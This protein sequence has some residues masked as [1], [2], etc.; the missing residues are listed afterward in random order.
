MNFEYFLFLV[1]TCAGI[2]SFGI[3][4]AFNYLAKRS[5]SVFNYNTKMKEVKGLKKDEVRKL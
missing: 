5:N 2:I 1:L 4:L 3:N